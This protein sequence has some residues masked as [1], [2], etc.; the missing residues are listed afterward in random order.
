MSTI[1]IMPLRSEVVNG[2]A[3]TEKAQKSDLRIQSIFQIQRIKMLQ[4]LSISKKQI[5]T[6]LTMQQ[7]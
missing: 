5:C 7:L 4:E 1:I 3:L 6:T 2:L